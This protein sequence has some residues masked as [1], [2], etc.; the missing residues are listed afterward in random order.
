MI[1]ANP[2]AQLVARGV[3]WSKG[4]LP[5]KK[6]VA[7]CGAGVLVDSHVSQGCG[8]HHGGASTPHPRSSTIWNRQMT[9]CNKRTFNK[10]LI[11]YKH[12][13][14][15][16][17]QHGASS[18]HK[19]LHNGNYS[20]I[21]CFCADSPCSSHIICNTEWATVTLHKYQRGMHT[22]M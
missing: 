11:L 17:S 20:N 10:I 14:S 21:L 8:R 9:I 4:R 6:Q 16:S 22:Q 1:M 7:G 13:L 3:W 2:A 15:T 12:L 19:V 18:Q 5:G